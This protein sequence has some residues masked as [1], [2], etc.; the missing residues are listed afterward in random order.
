MT[1]GFFYTIIS[2]MANS[3]LQIKSLKVQVDG[4]EILKGVDLDIK[5]GEI[6]ALMGPNGSGKSTLAQVLAGHPKYSVTAG[7][8]L[9]E[10]KDLLELSPNE[11]AKAG[12]F[13]AFQY[14]TGIPGVTL[15]NLLRQAYNNLKNEKLTPIRFKRHIADKLDML[16]FDENILDR[17]VNDG[18]SGGEKKKAEILQMSVLEPKLAILDETDSGLDVDALRIVAE[19]VKTIHKEKNNMGILI[20]T[21]YQRILQHIQ[22]DQV[23]VMVAGK[24]VKSGDHKLAKELE[25]SGYENIK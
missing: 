25:K 8:A 3:L 17:A 14:P 15:S 7:E 2:F 23:H 20:I 1:K 22:P 5:S 13:L 11:R 24:I 12:L 6:H 19:G 16:K 9:F 21:H 18:L 4:K 10:G